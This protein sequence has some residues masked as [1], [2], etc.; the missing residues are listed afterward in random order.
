MYYL[1]CP[2]IRVVCRDDKTGLDVD[3]FCACLSLCSYYI[4]FLTLSVYFITV[5]PSFRKDAMLK[6]LAACIDQICT[7]DYR[8]HSFNPKTT[9]YL[10]YAKSLPGRCVPTTIMPSQQ[11]V[12]SFTV[13]IKCTRA[14]FATY[15]YILLLNPMR[16]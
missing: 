9:S 14:L 10:L 6:E 7:C 12:L 1:H 4:N 15:Q 11:H 2:C 5:P 16:M 8:Y 13:H 3:S